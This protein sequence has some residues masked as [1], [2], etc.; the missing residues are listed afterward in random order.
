[1]LVPNPSSTMRNERQIVF[2][3]DGVGTENL[4]ASHRHLRVPSRTLKRPNFQHKR[5]SKWRTAPWTLPSVVQMNYLPVN[6]NPTSSK[7]VISLPLVFINQFPYHR[8]VSWMANASVGYENNTVEMIWQPVKRTVWLM[9]R[10]Y[11]ILSNQLYLY[12][13]NDCAHLRRPVCAG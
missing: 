5:V 7:L 4:L 13:E 12:R 6:P 10:Y 11:L 1:M 8:C 3:R 9:I 2:V